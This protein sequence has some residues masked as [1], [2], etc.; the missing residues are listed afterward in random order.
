MATVALKAVSVVP[1]PFEASVVLLPL[2]VLLL[3]LSYV[4]FNVKCI[5]KLAYGQEN[6]KCHVS[7]YHHCIHLEAL[8]SVV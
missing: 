5:A 1:K 8:L 6:F 7:S 4:F 3:F 2:S